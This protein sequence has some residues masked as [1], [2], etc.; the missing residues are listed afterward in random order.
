MDFG[1]RKGT[2]MEFRSDTTITWL[3]LPGNF[4]EKKSLET[5]SSLKLTIFLQ[6]TVYLED[7][8]KKLFLIDKNI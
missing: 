8:F 3:E 4:P 6:K 5:V 1:E 7:C 2:Q